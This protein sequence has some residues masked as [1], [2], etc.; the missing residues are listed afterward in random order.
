MTSSLFLQCGQLQWPFERISVENMKRKV[1]MNKTKFMQEI[2][3]VNK[4]SRKNIREDIDCSK[5][6]RLGFVYHDTRNVPPMAK[7]EAVKSKYIKL[8]RAEP[9]LSSKLSN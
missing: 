9:G 5:D 6:Y 4:C 3:M 2:I 1:Q 7:L 8:G